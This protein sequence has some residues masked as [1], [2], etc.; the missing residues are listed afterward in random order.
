MNRVNLGA[1]GL[2]IALT[3]LIVPATVHAAQP[4]IVEAQIQ[5]TA[6]VSYADL[7]LSDGSGVAR[8][9]ARVANA[10]DRLCLDI[11]RQPLNR[12][13]AGKACRKSAIEGADE[14]IRLAVSNF[15]SARYAALSRVAVTLR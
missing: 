1:A 14:Q 2:A 7:D 13:M 3:A 8:L 11:G 4:V 9:K 12:E 6:Y 5:P 15:G 10:A